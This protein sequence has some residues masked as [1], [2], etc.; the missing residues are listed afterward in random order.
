MRK[1]HLSSNLSDCIF[2]SW[3][4]VASP[5]QEMLAV[6]FRA[7]PC[8]RVALSRA[9]HGATHS[10]PYILSSQRPRYSDFELSASPIRHLSS[11]IAHYRPNNPDAST[12]AVTPPEKPA[13]RKGLLSR[14]LPSSLV[15]PDDS[16]GGLRRLVALMRPERKTLFI[17]VGLVSFVVSL[18][19]IAFIDSN[20]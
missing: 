1:E 17:A 9:Y 11:S 16:A 8:H 15:P 19:S 7:P 18:H 4:R 12:D 20:F 10:R 5:L 2:C 3:G 13:R 6:W 14:V